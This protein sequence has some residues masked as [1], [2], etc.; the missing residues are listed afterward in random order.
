MRNE[1]CK[2]CK[3][4]FTRQWN[5]QRHLKSIHNISDGKN[6]LFK[7]RYD[8][9][10]DV[11]SFSIKNEHASNPENKISELKPYRNTY[12]YQNFINRFYSNK[13]YNNGFY[14]NYELLPIEKKEPKLSL[15]D[16]IR[17]QR[18]SLILKNIL[19]RYY[20]EIIVNNSLYWVLR[21]C[22]TKQSDQPLKDCFKRYNLGHLWP[23]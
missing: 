11:D 1:E 7:Q 3:K 21:Q 9:P 16:Y 14:Q 10:I 18:A 17:I 2:V 12:K 6:N 15:Q 20:S 4:R 5:L 19:P 23:S 8:R 22:N 13:Y